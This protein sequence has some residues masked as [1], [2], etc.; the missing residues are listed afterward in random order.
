MSRPVVLAFAL[1]LVS[2]ATMRA[3][4]ADEALSITRVGPFKAEAG[5]STPFYLT[6]Q[7]TGHK[8]IIAI[9]AGPA[10]L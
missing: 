3:A 1:I 5:T 4:S 9:Q 6:I 8:A 2:L 7:N 10:L